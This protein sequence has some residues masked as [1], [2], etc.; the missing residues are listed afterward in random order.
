MS[1]CDIGVLLELTEFTYDLHSV[2]FFFN[3]FIFYLF[4]AVLRIELRAWASALPHEPCPSP[5]TQLFSGYKSSLASHHANA[6]ISEK[7]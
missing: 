2:L 6:G 5:F 1:F 4:L 3:Y 7:L